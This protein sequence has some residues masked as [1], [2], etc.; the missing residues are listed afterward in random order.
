[1]IFDY[2]DRAPLVD[3]D[4]VVTGDGWVGWVACS[5]CGTPLGWAQ[6]CANEQTPHPE[7][8]RK[9]AA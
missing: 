4:R 9:D 1:M 6:R 5:E 3:D 7:R 8:D 2:F